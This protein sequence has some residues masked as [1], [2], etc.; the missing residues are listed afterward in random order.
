M[1]EGTLDPSAP[2][3]RCVPELAESAWADATVQQTP[4]MTT[5][6]AYTEVFANPQSDIYRYLRAGGMILAKPG[7]GG[8]STLYDFLASTPVAA[9]P[10]LT[11]RAE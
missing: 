2:L 10:T 8:P 6:V 7:D 3:V 4:D 1:Q 9:D 5:W 11:T